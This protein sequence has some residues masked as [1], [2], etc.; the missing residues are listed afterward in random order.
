[1]KQFSAPAERLLQQAQTAGADDAEVLLQES[2][3]FSSR[4]RQGTVE[5]VKEATARALRLR[6]FVDQ[7]VA[8]ASSSD[9]RAETLEGLVRRAVERARLANQDPFAGLPENDTTPPEVESLGLYDSQIETLT[10]QEKL[11]LA[12]EA[13]E[14]GLSLDPRIRNSG[15]AG[16]SSTRGQVW[17]AN[18]RGFKGAYRATSCS[19]GLHL[20]GQEGSSGEQVSDYW[21]SAARHRARLESPEQIA[22]AAVARVQRHFGARKVAT[23]EVPVVFEPLVAAE[24]LQDMFGAVTG[25]AIYLRRSF[26]SEALG[27]KVAAE[28]VMLVDD[29]LLP[30]GLGTQPFDGEGVTSQRTVV[31]ERGVLQ[32]YLCGSYAARK[33]GRRSTANGTGD[34]E[35]PTNFYLAAGKQ[36]PD[37]IIASV[38]RGLYLTRLL[39]QGVN[40]VTGDYSRGAY[41]VWIEKGQFAYPVHEITVSSNLRRMLEGM[42][43]I[44]TDLEFRDPFAAPTVKI[45]AMTVGGR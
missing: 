45:A 33:L 25:E 8:R 26:L 41:G 1:M 20:L 42:E 21:F 34:G 4:V 22:R 16:F 29:G 12:R 37:E 36:E 9:L 10:A 27:E 19:L 7:R 2:T 6:V 14:I 32:N 13:E 15:G 35:A 31:V 23:E 5:T 40:L 24:L 38:E 18:T 43:M 3:R 39:G 28:G 30:G 17:L 11:A 44:G